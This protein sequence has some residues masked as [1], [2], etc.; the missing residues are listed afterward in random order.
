MTRHDTI[1]IGAGIAGC[2]A[3]RALT[4]AGQNVLVLEARTRVGG[5]IH[6]AGGF[7]LGAGWIHGTEGNPLTTLARQWDL[8]LLFVGGDS[9]YIGGWDRID[10]PRDCPSVAGGLDK[11]RSIIAADQMFDALEE[12]RGPGAPDLSFAA[13]AD[14]AITALGLSPEQAAAARWHVNLLA[15]DDCAADPASLSSRHWDDGYEVHGYGDSVLAC[16]MQPLVERLAAGLDIRLGAVVRAVAHSMDGV[17]ITTDDG[18]YRAQRAII[19]LPLGVLK[20]G[21]V[22]FEP[23][24]P[25]TKQAAID[26]LGF[27]ALAKLRVRFAAAHWPRHIYAFGLIPPLGQAAPAVAVNELPISGAPALILPIGAPDSAMVERMSDAERCIWVMAI[28]RHNFGAD[29]PDPIAID[30]TGWVDDPHAR[31]TYSYVATGGDASDFASLAAPIG[32]QLWFAGEATSPHQWATMHGAYVSGLSAAAAITGDPAMLPPLHFTENRRWRMQMSRANRFLNLRRAELGAG[33]IARRVALL[34]SAD[35]FAHV[36]RPELA[37]LATMLEP[38][39]LADGEI[40]CRHGD[41][42][43]EVYLVTT[44]ALTVHDAAGQ[45]I[46]NIPAVALTGEYGMFGDARRS[47]TL[48][49]AAD[50]TLLSLDYA[51]FRRFLLAF[52]Q[53]ALDLL[54]AG[55]GRL[56]R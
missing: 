41:V 46:G 56:L 55:I 14:A 20:A 43:D 33:E 18:E 9:S 22:R 19:T 2:A 40:L 30:A 32:D 52:P 11:D 15:R 17:R 53:T 54:G 44:G 16:G 26:R 42:A 38:R 10:F 4:D 5:R 39:T 37:M 28:L 31:G 34:S 3:A 29:L 36:D 27:G 25:P 8:P 49:A 47:A 51:R 1:V 24:L 6:T 21:A 45:A 12:Q 23:P 48:V 35:V 50:T 7:D 13:A